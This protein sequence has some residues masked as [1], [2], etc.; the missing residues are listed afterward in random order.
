[1]RRQD[2][3]TIKDLVPVYLCAYPNLVPF[4]GGDRAAMLG[5]ESA[6]DFA[7]RKIAISEKRSKECQHGISPRRD[8]KKCRK[9]WQE[10]YW[11]RKIEHISVGNSA[12]A[13]SRRE[14]A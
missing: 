2:H 8:C 3:E 5:F 13:E 12:V 1:M 11:R 14:V 6:A 7:K 4:L 10:K 9:I